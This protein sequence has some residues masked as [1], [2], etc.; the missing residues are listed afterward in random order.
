MSY[1]VFDLEFNQSYNSHKEGSNVNPL[2]PFEIIQLG[3]IKL[4]KNL[5]ITSV[6]DRLVKPEVYSELNPF[7][8]DLT[9]INPEELYNA[10]PFKDVFEEFINFIED[11]KNI[12][13]IWGMTDIKELLRNV[14][15]HKLDLSV[16]P[17]D[18]I[19]IQRYASRYLNCPKGTNIGLHKAV[20]SYG[21]LTNYEFHNAINDAYYTAEVFNRIFNKK[22]KPKKYNIEDYIAPKRQN[23]SKPKIDNDKLISQ[24]EKMFNREMTEE[25]KSI[26]KLAYMMGRTNQFQV[27]TSD[28]EKNQ[29]NAREQS[30]EH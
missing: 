6:L 2:C 13:C 30:L 20:E 4:D 26:I 25:E 21:I 28:S 22:I 11:S 10:N 15:Y 14:H 1:I 9:N 16:I 3:A 7:I 12:L 18:Y 29:D 8:K 19:D 24:F 17:R 5:K 27:D 23:N